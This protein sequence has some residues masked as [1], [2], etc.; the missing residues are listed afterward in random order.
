MSR[1]ACS[2]TPSPPPA[3]PTSNAWRPPAPS[4][5]LTLAIPA[6]RRSKE[7]TGE[8]TRPRHRSATENRY[9]MAGPEYRL[10][11]RRPDLRP[12]TTPTQ[13]PAQGPLDPLAP[14]PPRPRPDQPLPPT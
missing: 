11:P 10:R 8:T 7:R 2:P 13:P 6:R 9:R 1:S 5:P 12:P 14:D 4:S 3:A